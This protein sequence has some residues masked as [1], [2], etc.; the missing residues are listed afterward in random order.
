M[1]FIEKTQNVKYNYYD[2]TLFLSKL[3]SIIA[4]IITHPPINTLK[5]GISFKN[6]HTQIGA[7]KVSVNIKRPIVVEGVVLDPIV[8]HEHSSK[9]DAVINF[10]NLFVL[11]LNIIETKKN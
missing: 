5:G 4:V 3:L 10:S 1:T 9:F 2:V 7:N 8:I 11:I 6:N